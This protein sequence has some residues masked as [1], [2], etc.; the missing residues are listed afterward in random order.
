MLYFCVGVILCSSVNYDD[1]KYKVIV[2]DE[3]VSKYVTNLGGTVRMQKREPPK[4]KDENTVVKLVKIRKNTYKIKYSDN[5]YFC[6]KIHDPGV[7]SFSDPTQGR[8]EWEIVEVFDTT[9]KLMADGRCLVYKSYDSRASSEGNYLNIQTCENND[10]RA[11][12]RVIDADLPEN[13][14]QNWEPPT[15]EKRPVPFIDLHKYFNDDFRHMH[16]GRPRMVV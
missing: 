2:L 10:A 15:N 12:W 11:L 14:E 5:T 1:D 9:I 16:H 3:D 13:D 7:V 4:S 6:G 8:C